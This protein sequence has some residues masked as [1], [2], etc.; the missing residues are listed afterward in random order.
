MCPSHGLEPM[1]LRGVKR[2]GLRP[3]RSRACE[4]AAEAAPEA[5]DSRKRIREPGR[6][7]HL[8]VKAPTSG[9][10]LL[11]ASAKSPLFPIETEGLI[12]R[13]KLMNYRAE[14]LRK[15]PVDLYAGVSVQVVDVVGPLVARLARLA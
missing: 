5:A 8:N 3:I 1:R 7:L 6:W 2:I 11:C 12:K 4:G 14:T 15:E 10:F 9:A 13:S